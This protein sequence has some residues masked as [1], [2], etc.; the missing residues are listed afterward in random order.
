LARHRQGLRMVLDAD[1]KG[2]F[3]HASHYTPFHESPSKRSG[4][5][6]IALMHK[7]F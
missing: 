4:C 2:F 3:D 7:P 6:P 5:G 1:I